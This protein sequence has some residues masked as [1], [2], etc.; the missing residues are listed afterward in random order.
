LDR[1]YGRTQ[2]AV[3]HFQ[4]AIRLEPYMAGPRAELANV[5]QGLAGENAEV[6]RLRNEEAELLER[7]AGLAPENAEV[8]YQLGL[9]RYLLGELDAAQTALSAACDHSPQNYEYLMALA[10]LHE[11]RYELTSDQ[12][13]FE[14]A[15]R[16][17]KK[18]NELQPDD[19]RAGQILVR[20]L[21]TKKS[22]R[23]TR[24]PPPVPHRQQ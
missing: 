23:H 22:R 10:L 17:L 16:T 12:S 15:V 7:D 4:A 13:Q 8:R 11:R 14:D 5:L 2:Q 9:L 19:V 3:E 24:D 20:L 21:A 6:R 18:M 1:H